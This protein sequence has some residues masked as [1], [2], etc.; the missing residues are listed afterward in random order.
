MRFWTFAPAEPIETIG[1]L[2]AACESVAF[3]PAARVRVDVTIA[4]RIKAIKVEDDSTAPV[5][6][7]APSPE[8]PPGEVTR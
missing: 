3:N 4:G 8:V 5:A 2:I 6:W 1:E 7:P